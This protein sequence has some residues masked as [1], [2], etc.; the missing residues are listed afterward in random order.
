M[1]LGNVWV[2]VKNSGVEVYS[3]LAL[4]T[5]TQGTLFR[6][7]IVLD[8]TTTVVVN[9]GT[10]WVKPLVARS[11]DPLVLG[12]GETIRLNPGG[13]I[14]HLNDEKPGDWLGLF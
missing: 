11:E 14:V 5:A 13:A 7:R 2:F 4:L 1:R 6:I 3:P 10:V 9:R 12:P 8:A